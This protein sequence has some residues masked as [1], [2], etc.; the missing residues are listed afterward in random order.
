MSARTKVSATVLIMTGAILCSPAVAQQSNPPAGQS[1]T[2][3]AQQLLKARD[4]AR[5]KA[6]A[7]E[8]RLRAGGKPYDFQGFEKAREARDR[9]LKTTKNPR[10]KLVVYMEYAK[11]AKRLERQIHDEVTRGLHPADFSVIA[12]FERLQAD[13]ELAQAEGRLPVPQEKGK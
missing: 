7:A 13:V 4:E 5:P 9:Q 2:N 1:P 3:E 10:E 11:A 8:K 12:H 6:K